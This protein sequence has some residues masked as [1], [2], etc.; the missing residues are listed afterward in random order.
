LAQL[1]ERVERVE[2]GVGLEPLPDPPKRE[3][4]KADD[5]EDEEVEENR[6][7][8]QYWIAYGTRAAGGLAM[9]MVLVWLSVRP[10]A[11]PALGWPS[12]GSGGGGES[13]YRPAS[14]GFRPRHYIVPGP[15]R[16]SPQR[17]DPGGPPTYVPGQHEF[18][19]PYRPANPSTPYR[20]TNPSV[21]YR[22]SPTR[23]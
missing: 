20:P 2:R 21:P 6:N 19:Q 13:E 10:P 14:F 7:T 3:R 1:A 22:P 12:G 23:R 11:L 18:P 16:P 5:E 17:N 4:K 15:Y 9:L 8:R